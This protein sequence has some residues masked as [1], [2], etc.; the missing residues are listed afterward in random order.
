MHTKNTCKLSRWRQSNTKWAEAVRRR[1][2][3]SRWPP[4]KE[5]DGQITKQQENENKKIAKYHF[6]SSNGYCF[7]G[8]SLI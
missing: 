3:Q 6:N 4:N 8:T 7:N 2:S 5:K 1:Q